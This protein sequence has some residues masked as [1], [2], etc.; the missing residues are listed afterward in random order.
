MKYTLVGFFLNVS[1]H[2]RSIPGV[3]IPNRPGHYEPLEVQSRRHREVQVQAEIK[4]A[5]ERSE[6][7]RTDRDPTRMWVHGKVVEWPAGTKSCY[8]SCPEGAHQC[9]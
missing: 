2:A 7:W 8:V 1:E 6:G 9:F 3:A 4:R 5:V